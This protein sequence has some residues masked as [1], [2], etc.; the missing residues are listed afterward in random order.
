MQM[1]LLA[2]KLKT[3]FNAYQHSKKQRKLSFW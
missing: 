3:T 2:N 1:S